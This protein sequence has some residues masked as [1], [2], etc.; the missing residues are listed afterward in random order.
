MA[1]AKRSAFGA[2]AAASADINEAIVDI[3]P[4]AAHAI[5]NPTTPHLAESHPVY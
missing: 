3:S 1:L 4:P 5:A 2:Q